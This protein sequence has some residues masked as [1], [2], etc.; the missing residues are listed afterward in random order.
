MTDFKEILIE[1]SEGNFGSTKYSLYGK[2]KIGKQVREGEFYEF[3]R[4]ER[5]MQDNRSK[6]I[7]LPKSEVDTYFEELPPLKEED[8]EVEKNIKTKVIPFGLTGQIIEPEDKNKIIT[9]NKQKGEEDTVDHWLIFDHDN[10]TKLGMSRGA[11]YRVKKVSIDE[12]EG[13]FFVSLSPS[14]C[15]L[16]GQPKIIY[17]PINELG[18][19]NSESK[20]ILCEIFYKD[21][22]DRM[23]GGSK[24]K[25][26]KN[27]RKSNRRKSNRR[28]SNRRR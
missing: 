19:G 24:Q 13:P 17:V 14:P 3:E 4:K 23:L 7:Y 28:K 22:T 26:R 25:T 27:R 20:S 21:Y 8:T 18:M 10:L 11:E 2:Y 5:N 12:N 6:V 15:A 9:W 16:S 1:G